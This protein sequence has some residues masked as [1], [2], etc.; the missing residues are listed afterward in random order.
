MNSW[1]LEPRPSKGDIDTIEVI[2]EWAL[3]Y[4]QDLEST[5][6]EAFPQRKTF[7]GIRDKKMLKLEQGI[8]GKTTATIDHRDE[9]SS[10]ISHDSNPFES[11]HE[12]KIGNH[13]N[14]VVQ[15]VKN[16]KSK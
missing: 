3:V 15:S 6:S 11:F 16:E 8:I 12:A 2:D 9:G 14:T 1:M 4:V 5:K 7:G 10:I 13:K